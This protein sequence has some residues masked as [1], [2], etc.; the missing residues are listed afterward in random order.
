[1]KKNSDSH[2][3]EKASIIHASGSGLQLQNLSNFVFALVANK[4][5]VS[6]P[7]LLQ[8]T[9][10]IS[11]FR[12]HSTFVEISLIMYLLKN[13]VPPECVLRT[14]TTVC[15]HKTPK[16]CEQSCYTPL[17]HFVS[18]LN[19][20]SSAR[21]K[22]SRRKYCIYPKLPRLPK[23]HHLYYHEGLRNLLSSSSSEL[24]SCS[25]LCGSFTS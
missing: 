8:I 23:R 11:S 16:S 22:S 18:P 20:L 19:G 13:F 24:T 3:K 17:H 12:H 4:S 10:N 21:E 15:P 6:L 5:T 7:I 2:R 25:R 1:M 14:T 9:S